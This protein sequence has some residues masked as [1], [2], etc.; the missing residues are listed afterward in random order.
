MSGRFDSLRLVWRIHVAIERGPLIHGVL[1]RLSHRIAREGELPL[2]VEPGPKESKMIQ[3][4]PE[5][6]GLLRDAGWY[7]GRSILDSRL[8]EFAA[9]LRNGGFSI[10]QIVQE[11]LN[12]FGDLHIRVP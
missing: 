3:F 5:T 1:D 2:V 7:P 12:E 9:I 10:P 4:S 6:E 8:E 11:F